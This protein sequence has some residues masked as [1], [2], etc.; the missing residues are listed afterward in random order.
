MVAAMIAVFIVAIAIPEAWHDD[1]GGLHGATVIA[2]AYIVIRLIHEGLYLLAA[3]DDLALRC[4]LGLNLLPLIGGGAL[5]LIGSRAHD[6]AQTAI[7]AAALAVDWADV[8][9][10]DA[11][12]RLAH[13]STDHWVERHGLVVILAL[14][15]S[16]VAI[17]VGAAEGRLDWELLVGASLGIVTATAL[18]WLYFDVSADAAQRALN[19]RDTDGRVRA[20]IESYTYIH[21]WSILGIVLTAVGIEGVLAQAHTN[22][23][24]GAFTA[25]CLT[26]GPAMYLTSNVIS[27]LRLSATVKKPRIVTSV[28]LVAMWPVASTVTPLVALAVVS[29]ALIAFV[30]FE[31]IRYANVRAELQTT[32]T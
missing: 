14:G 20:A 5:L 31:T 21:Y 25:G 13:N 16:I 8:H 28:G 32:R 6:D 11:R 17:G 26:L 19:R 9:H 23:S 24:L 1:T 18:W 4:Q 7:W 27:W 29:A 10:V 2:V 3:D 12:T 15:E 30:V 22:D